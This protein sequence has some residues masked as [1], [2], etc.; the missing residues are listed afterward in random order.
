MHI[1]RVRACGR[2]KETRRTCENTRARDSSVGDNITSASEGCDACS[3]LYFLSATCGTRAIVCVF[4][5][6]VYSSPWARA[7]SLDYKT[8]SLVRTRNIHSR[9]TRR[10]KSASTPSSFSLV[11][12]RL[13]RRNADGYRVCLIFLSLASDQGGSPAEFK[14]ISKRRKRN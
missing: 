10:P 14:H 9:R 13:R 2:T 8:M 1:V 6:N 3:R 11:R 5:S 12:V 4:R 7:T